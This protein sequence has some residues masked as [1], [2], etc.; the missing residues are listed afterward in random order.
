MKLITR[1][2]LAN[3][4]AEAWSKQYPSVLKN[5]AGTN[6]EI[7]T[8]L[9]LLGDNPDPNKV[10]EIIG[11]GTWTTTLLFCTECQTKAD[12]VQLGEE[13]EP[14]SRTAWVCKSCLEKA[15]DLFLEQS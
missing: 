13:P 5:I 12:V 14:A 7:Y 6:F 8:K 4:A 11:N 2:V 1:Q 3:T 15:L 9:L 10:D